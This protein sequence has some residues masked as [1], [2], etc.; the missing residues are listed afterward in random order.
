MNKSTDEMHQLSRILVVYEDDGVQRFLKK[1]L[2]THGYTVVETESISAGR[3]AIE[4]ERIDLVIADFEMNR[5]VE[6]RSATVEAFCLEAKDL[7]KVP[8][9]VLVTPGTRAHVIAKRDFGAE[10]DRAAVV[11]KPLSIE[12]IVSSVAQLFLQQKIKQQGAEKGHR[13]EDFCPIMLED[14]GV[15]KTLPFA[16]YLRLGTDRSICFKG[17]SDVWTVDDAKAF[18]TR[19]IRTFQVLRGEFAIWLQSNR[20]FEKGIKIVPISDDARKK[21]LQLSRDTVMEY[22]YD[23]KIQKRK[24]EAAMTVMETAISSCLDVEPLG[25]IF[26]TMLE[27]LPGVTKQSIGVC[28]FVSLLSREQQIRSPHTLFQLA[29]AAIYHNIGLREVSEEIMSK[30]RSEWTLDQLKAFESHPSRSCQILVETQTLSDELLQWI[31]QHHEN[32]AGT[33]FPHRLQ[34]SK[35][36]KPAAVLALAERFAEIVVGTWGEEEKTISLPQAW[37][38]LQALHSKEFDSESITAFG[39][40]LGCG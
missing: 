37:S 30:P 27:S 11:L 15:E 26:Q 20:V 31:L 39:Q 14:L 9:V 5:D 12:G 8:T 4:M 21:A 7:F 23:A 16:V 2:E 33:G 28:F 40:V 24:L 18:E 10:K 32:I 35:I 29:I 3:R 6:D 17:K 38:R 19:G 13:D 22:F 34:R 36:S 25:K 1:T